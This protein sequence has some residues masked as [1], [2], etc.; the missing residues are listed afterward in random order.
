[1]IEIKHKKRENTNQKKKLC[2]RPTDA[3]RRAT[4]NRTTTKNRKCSCSTDMDYFC[5]QQHINN[6]NREKLALVSSMTYERAGT[7]FGARSREPTREQS[8]ATTSCQQR[9]LPNRKRLE[10]S[11]GVADD[12]NDRIVSIRVYVHFVRLFVWVCVSWATS[13]EPSKNS[14]TKQSAGAAAATV[15][16]NLNFKC[17]QS[18]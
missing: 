5:P 17:T 15:A 8:R 7:R 11:V 14:N 6:G 10:G 12:H 3:T 2:A 4:S 18:Q 13:R 16:L 9:E 1:M